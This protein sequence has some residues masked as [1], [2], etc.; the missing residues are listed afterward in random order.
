MDQKLQIQDYAFKNPTKTQHDFV[1]WAKQTFKVEI[2]RTTVQR[3]LA[4]PREKLFSANL[5]QKKKRR[6]Q[7]PEFEEELLQFVLQNEG[8]VPLSE[9]VI[10]EKGQ[11][12]LEKHGI[13]M[14]LSNGWIT[15]FK[16]RNGIRE[17][18]LHGEEG[19]VDLYDY[20]KARR[21]LQEI[22]SKFEPQDVFN[23][24]ESALFYKLQPNK[25]LATYRKKGC[26][27][28]KDRFTLGF[29]CN[30]DGSEKPELLVIGKSAKPRCFKQNPI[31]KTQFTIIVTQKHG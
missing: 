1:A 27:Q 31:E 6:V 3:I 20:E 22:I 8:K 17:C 18:V 28:S 19:S 23:F 13:Q 2:G 24:D 14:Q 21:D 15:K 29:C 26:K 11:R 5:Q 12:L 4:T 30:L 10:T 9:A 7:Y 16:R 25:T